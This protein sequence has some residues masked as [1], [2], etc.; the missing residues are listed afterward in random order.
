MLYRLCS[1]HLATVCDNAWCPCLSGLGTDTLQGIQNLVT[2]DNLSE[3]A[4]LT[5]EPVAWNEAHEELGTIGV[6][7]SIG[8]REVPSFGVL[9]QEVLVLEFFTIDRLSTSSISSC[10]VSTLSHE[11]SDD[12][13]EARSLVV[14]WLTGF[15]NTFLTC[16][17]ASEI[18]SSLWCLVS[19]KLN[20]DSS[21]LL[22]TNSDIHPDV[23]VWHLKDLID[24]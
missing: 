15:S 5:I 4:M 1:S 13:M 7:T 17:E 11:L 6:G 3:Y 8:H 16:A 12:T 10:K 24:Y 19:I 2:I 23:W 14:K 22:A 20:R 21:N 9:H 18:L